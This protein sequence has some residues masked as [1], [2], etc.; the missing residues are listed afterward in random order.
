MF[1]RK[2]SHLKSK[3]RFLLYFIQYIL[4][5]PA[6]SFLR[7]RG[8][9]QDLWI[10]SERGTDARDNGYHLFRYIRQNYPE[11]NIR[12]IISVD[13]PDYEKV[14]S[15]GEIIPYRSFRHMLAFLLSEVKISTHI[16]GYAADMYFF[17][18]LDERMPISGIKIFLQHGI[19]MH[20]PAWLDASATNLDLFVC[21]AKREYEFVRA[22]FGYPA[23]VVQKLG[24]C[25][26]DNLQADKDRPKSKIIL[27]MPTWRVYLEGMSEKAFKKSNYYRALQSML[28]DRRI[29]KLLDKYGY[30]VDFY[31]H[32]EMEG[33]MLYFHVPSEVNL[34]DAGGS[35]IQQMLIQADILVTDYSSVAFDFAYMEKPVIY[36]QPDREEF[37]S[38]HFQ[39][40]YFSYET[41]GFGPVA[42]TPEELAGYLEDCLKANGEIKP[43]YKKRV[44][45]FFEYQ[46]QKNCERNFQAI[47]HLAKGK[48]GSA[49]N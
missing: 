31:P 35:D 1:S 16:M 18:L 34:L 49:E 37:F 39:K 41:D 42:D 11:I 13:S 14:A 25:R 4:A 12:Y 46:D 17:K 45:D 27:F 43:D 28:S 24:M 44:K 8:K 36:Y 3:L 48:Q 47:L 38:G 22:K 23:G 20:N 40:G 26:Y 29:R 2:L 7:S 33:R 32:P 9:Y 19:T 5:V 30:T 10:I 21:T 15:L 6:S